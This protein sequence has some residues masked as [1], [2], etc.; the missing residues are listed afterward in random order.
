MVYA[1]AGSLLQGLRALGS[2]KDEATRS[3]PLL[4]NSVCVGHGVPNCWS[5][6]NSDLAWQVTPLP[7]QKFQSLTTPHLHQVSRP[8]QSSGNVCRDH[9]LNVSKREIHL[10]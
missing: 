4:N 9:K 8:R 1:V 5:V 7:T 2:G 3:T 6:N 10:V